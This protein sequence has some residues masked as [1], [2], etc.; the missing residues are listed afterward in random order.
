M[1]EDTKNEKSPEAADHAIERLVSD[2]G[3]RWRMARYV[4][5]LLLAIASFN[6]VLNFVRTNAATGIHIVNQYER[7]VVFRFGKFAG[8]ENPG[9][10]LAIPIWES[11]LKKVNR[12]RLLGLGGLAKP[13]LS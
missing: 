1:T 13:G 8:I 9:L 7:G 4:G 6:F 10:D 2:V 11:S 3:F 5:L 12:F